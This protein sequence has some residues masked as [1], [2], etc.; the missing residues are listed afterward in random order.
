MKIYGYNKL[1]LLDYP[2][3]LAAT[4]FLGGC[5]FR[6]PYC[7]NA[8]LID[9]PAPH[10]PI[11]LWEITSFLKK[12]RGVLEGVCISGGEPTLHK[13]LP[14]LINEIRKL[15]FKIK[16]DTNGSRPDVIKSL[17]QKGL[18]DMVA[19]DIKSSLE[20]Y[21]YAAGTTHID[22]E[23]V[24]ESV[25]FLLQGDLEYEFRTTVVEGL[26]TEQIARDIGNWLKGGDKYFL[27]PYKESSGVL[28]PGL[29]APSMGELESYRAILL[30]YIKH[31]EIRGL[32]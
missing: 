22:K 32:E 29:A 23:K 30:P 21:Q 13:D 28:R 15:D 31:V 3:H 1:T 10:S 9:T 20:N 16:I 2:G 26:F 11:D 24:V 18:I 19:M 27:Q 7:H 6:C 5:N 25:D 8:A 4:L 12:R 14:E 17:T